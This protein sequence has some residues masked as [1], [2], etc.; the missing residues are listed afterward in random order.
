[1]AMPQERLR[2][3]ERPVPA[4]A[5]AGW[6]SWG[7]VW[8]GF[9]VGLGTL[10][11]LGT[12]GLAIG[13][14]AA[15]VGTGEGAGARGLGIGAGIWAFISMLIAYFLGGA[16]AARM[17]MIWDNATASLHGVL[18][19]TLG[20]LATL[21][22]ATT[23][24]GLGLSTLFGVA[25]G[26]AQTAV[27]TGASG[28][29]EL[30][31]GDVDQILARLDDPRTAQ[32]MAAATGMPEDEARAQLTD[33]RQRVEAARSDPARAAA[34]AREGLQRLAAQAGERVQAAAQAAQ[35]AAAATSWATFG[36]LVVSLLA[37][38]AGAIWGSRRARL[39]VV[40]G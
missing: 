32:T 12:L 18:V 29:S 20:A 28:L 22:L 15:D 11:L 33:I 30:S 38:V 23:G 8:S 3:I 10:L 4:L 1:M 26:I 24:I 27:S 40:E 25:G 17:G 7:G 19:W 35:P 39:R 6:L 13:V 21:V 31:T 37:A 16:V 34:E 14:T 36:A 9:L 2:T 5:E